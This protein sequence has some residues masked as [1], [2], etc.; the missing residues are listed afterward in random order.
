M[1]IELEIPTKW[2]GRYRPYTPRYDEEWKY[3]DDC[4]DLG[5]AKEAVAHALGE[6]AYY[7]V[8]LGAWDVEFEWRI[9]TDW[10]EHGDG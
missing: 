5:D 7:K 4:D 10:Q 2:R 1:K 9:D 3:T 6:T 8:D